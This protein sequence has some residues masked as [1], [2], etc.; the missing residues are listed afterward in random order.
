[1]NIKQPGPDELAVSD[2]P[3]FTGGLCAVLFLFFVGMSLQTAAI[4]P[5]NGKKIIGNIL[6]GLVAGIG[7]AYFFMRSVVRFDRRV[8][9]A[10]WIRQGILGTRT[11]QISLSDIQDVIVEIL[12]D[13]RGSNTYSSN[14]YRVALLTTAGRWPLTEYYSGNKADCEKVKDTVRTFLG[15][16]EQPV[17]VALENRLRSLVASGQM[18]EAIKVARAERNLSL[19]QAKEFVEDLTRLPG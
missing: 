13:T 7:A 16:P 17:D 1:M 15:F 5:V 18:I 11:G 4:P 14:T 3:V 8:G 6:G 2:F 10:T 9:Q 12:S 19:K